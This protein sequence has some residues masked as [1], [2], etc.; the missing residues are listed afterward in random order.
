[1]SEHEPTAALYARVSSEQQAEAGTIE[2]QVAALREQIQQDEYLCP[3]EMEFIDNGYSGTTLIRPALEQLR[4]LIALH[5]L[6]RLYVLSADR[7]ARQYAYQVL[8]VEEFQ[9]CGVEMVFLNHPVGET[10]ED[11]L[12]LQMQGMIA[13]YEWA[14]I[15]ERSRRGKR[16]AARMGEVAVMSGAPY[17]YHYIRSASKTEMGRRGMRS[18]CKLRKW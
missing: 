17:G 11:Q 16:H 10:A 14:K 7:L 2:S 18:I 3:G 1:M 4:D 6:N 8:L 5:G 9:R 15:M 12:L 13:E